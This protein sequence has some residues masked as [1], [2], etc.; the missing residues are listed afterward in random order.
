LRCQWGDPEINDEK[1]EI[2]AALRARRGLLDF[3]FLELDV[4]ARDGIVFLENKLFRR[5]AGVL[6]RDVE[7]AS[8]GRRQQLDLLGNGLRHG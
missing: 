7:K 6:F 1:V 8:P 3:R 5:R 4:L 2:A